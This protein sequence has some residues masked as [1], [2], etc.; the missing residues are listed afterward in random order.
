MRVSRR[1]IG[2]CGAAA[3]LVLTG[4]AAGC[5]PIL[6]ARVA[7]EAVRRKLDVDVA[8]ARPGWF[9]VR[10]GDVRVRPTGVT[11]IDGHFDE[12]RVELGFFLSTEAIVARKGTIR[13][14][15]SPDDV[16][17]QL[18]AWRGEATGGGSESKRRVALR[19][20]E[21]SLDWRETEGG[22]PIASASG[23][24]LAREAEGATAAIETATLHVGDFEVSV[25][26]GS[27]RFD[28]AGTLLGAKAS[29]VDVAW[30]VARKHEVVAPAVT[31]AIDPVP[32]PLPVAI[33]KRGAAAPK[34]PMDPASTAPLLSLPDLHAIR[35]RVAAFATVAEVHVPDGAEISV[36]GL[37]LVARDG[38][39]RLAIGPGP[40]SIVRHEK[41][42]DV[43]FTTKPDALGTPLALTGQL[44]LDP[45]DP[46]D[47]VL[48]LA[49]GPISLALLGGDSA[50]AGL[51]DVAQ[52][53]LAGKGRV[54]L[55]GSG[56]ALTFDAEL[57]VRGLSLHQ[58]RLAAETV[59]G[60]DLGLIA[61]GVMSDRGELRL[62]DLE[63]S[64][65]ALHVLARGG[66]QQTSES[67][68]GGLTFEFPTAGCQ[69]LLDSVPSALVPSLRGAR[70]SGTLGG[71]GR[72]V[73]DSRKLDELVLQYDIEDRCK[74]TEVP[75]ALDRERFT[76]TFEHTIYLPDGKLATE[77]SG[78]GSEN[79]TDLDHIS[80][81][82][83]VAVLT[84]EDGAFLHHRGFNHF[85]IR[86]ALVANLKARRFVRGASTIT[87]QLAKN[88]FLTREKTMSRKLEEL[89]LADY[90]EQ[91]FTK[92][93]MMELYL[94]IIEFG[95]KVYG[96]TAAAAHYFGRKPAEL[97]LAECLF[98]ASI[99]PSP[100]RYHKLFEKH[101]ISE[102]WLKHVRAL[103]VIAE[104]T[105]KISAAELE[106][107]LNE[108]IV[109]HDEKL[110]PPAPRPPVNSAHF[111]GDD[112]Q[113]WQELN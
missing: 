39:E 90:L 12:V 58:P 70:M 111:L 48:S 28:A 22:V 59:H 27:A 93:E 113:E 102:T 74:M 82:M 83:Q 77:T 99:L 23:V 42:L 98:L 37:A 85:A 33:P 91:V 78:P 1:T 35:G 38:Q 7:R 57:A 69:S 51:T 9:A 55:S 108:P 110:P 94:N 44:P 30:D 80:P 76:K 67:L 17:E 60:I 75:E 68:A 79:W 63:A 54:A 45:H 19:T 4:A 29:N 105:G 20:E 89:I 97:N 16:R 106:A 72:V 26:V 8:S 36:D 64:L 52:S 2:L 31:A 32:P 50:V 15:G 11:A 87:M 96:V 92:Q 41:Q 14:H 100:V 101:E 46:G 53:T 49:G 104:K 73:L 3:A 66:L 88:L 34:A 84:T 24:S 109:F 71:R 65:G 10:L 112:P 13:V 47:V 25:G 56:D 18:R 81:F 43:T 61:R 21:M 62:D 95:P 6:R 5:G 86:N 107:G 40:F 103:M